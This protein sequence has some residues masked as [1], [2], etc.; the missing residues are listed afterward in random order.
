[1]DIGEGGGY[2]VNLLKEAL[3]PYKDD[4]ETI[5]MFTDSYDVIFVAGKEEIVKKFKETG[6]NIV[7]SKYF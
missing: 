5:V 1:M 3:R 4:T 7:I 6:S 2:K